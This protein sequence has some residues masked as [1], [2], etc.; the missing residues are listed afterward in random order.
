MQGDSNHERRKIRPRVLHV[1]DNPD[2]LELFAAIFAKWFD[3]KSL[4]DP[5]RAIEALRAEHFDTVVT[6]YEMPLMNGLDLL[7][8]VRAEMPDLPVLL[9]TGQGNEEIA[10]NALKGGA[11]DY[12]VKDISGFAHRE[13]LANA[14]WKAVSVKTEKDFSRK[15]MD[16]EFTLVIGLDRQGNILIF[17]RAAEIITGYSRAE[18]IN[19]N[20]FEMFV[21]AGDFSVVMA[22]FK[23]LVEGGVPSMYE[24]PIFARSGVRRDILWQN[25]VL[26]V[27]GIVSGTL[28]L[29]LDITERKQ[30]ENEL[31]EKEVF[32]RT[33]MD[34]LP[35]GIA[36][37]SVGQDVQ[38]EY[39]NDNFLK[40]YG[41]TREAVADPQAFWNVVYEDPHFREE[42]MQRVLD[43]CASA[44][45]ARMCWEDVPLARRGEETRFVT[46]RNIPIPDRNLMIST[47]MDVTQRK[48]AEEALKESEKRYRLIFNR[49]NDSI[50]VHRFMGPDGR[51][52]RFIEVNDAACSRLGYSR[53]ELL[54]MAPLN[55]DAPENISKLPELMNRLK[56]DSYAV[57][58]STHVARDGRRIP[59]EISS[60]VFEMDGQPTIMSIVRDITERKQQ[61]QG[62]AP[63]GAQA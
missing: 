15:L 40:I 20:W 17:N 37:N 5:K 23:R 12:F 38:F 6:D 18:V 45:P 26:K 63:K 44:D 39:V 10:R 61:E 34:H 47:V 1:D 49:G 52:G 54:Q 46:A 7:Q 16:T 4:E 56:A 43:D 42:I 50:F 59:V 30:A 55:I 24:S 36:V 33:V 13:K 21:P 3:V 60:Q 8:A 28:S 29:G 62:E 58:E 48:K 19:R 31:R 14:V 51:P 41:I 9:Y 32:I 35:I 25:D 53:E 2:F 22:E 27:H 11:F 57:W